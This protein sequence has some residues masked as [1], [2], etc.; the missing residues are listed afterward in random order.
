LPVDP[1]GLPANETTLIR[2]AK[3]AGVKLNCVNIMTMDFGNGQNVLADAESAATGT[4]RQ[5][6]SIYPGLTPARVWDVLGL[7]PIA[8][9]NDDD[10]RFTRSDAWALESF[11]AAKGV[12]LLAFWEVSAYDRPTGY[13]YSK[14]FGRI[15]S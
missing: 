7:T 1:S 11:A 2:D 14:I 12:Q 5:L 9:M 3:A 6:A 4:E 10:E 13:A 15:V 8:G